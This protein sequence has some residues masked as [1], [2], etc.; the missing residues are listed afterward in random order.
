MPLT[1]RLWEDRNAPLMFEIARQ[2]TQLPLRH[3]ATV[4]RVL[5]TFRHWFLVRATCLIGTELTRDR[6]SE[7]AKRCSRATGGYL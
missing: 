1:T 6:P 2:V 3:A 4:K 5:F 7:F